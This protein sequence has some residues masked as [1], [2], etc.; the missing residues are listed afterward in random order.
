MTSL[1]ATKERISAMDGRLIRFDRPGPRGEELNLSIRPG[2]YR[3]PFSPWSKVLLVDIFADITP[4][5]HSDWRV[6]YGNSV[7][8]PNSYA[9]AENLRRYFR[10]G[11][12]LQ[13]YADKVWAGQKTGSRAFDVR[14][15]YRDYG[16][17]A[18][19]IVVSAIALNKMRTPYAFIVPQ[20]YLAR[21]AWEEFNTDSCRVDS[22]DQSAQFN[23]FGRD[24]W[25]DLVRLLSK[26]EIDS[27]IARFLEE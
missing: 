5:G 14:R 16:I 6:I 4:I 17:E 22:S 15:D 11:D 7:N 23:L 20:S 26:P 18:L 27:S 2:S 8:L 19:L 24:S 1:A 3:E 21:K 9:S 13:K 25:I 12:D 10:G